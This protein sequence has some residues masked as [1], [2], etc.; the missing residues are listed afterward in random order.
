MKCMQCE[1]SIAGTGCTKNGICG[2][3]GEL[4]DRMDKLIA[5]LIEL[6]SATIGCKNE[7]FIKEMDE[8]VVDSVHDPV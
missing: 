2:K 4:A 5:S 3:S 1:E 7:G 6:S 8:H